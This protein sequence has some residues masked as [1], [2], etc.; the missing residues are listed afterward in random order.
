M[1]SLNFFTLLIAGSMLTACGETLENEQLPPDAEHG[2]ETLDGKGDSFSVRPG[3]PEAEAVLRYVNQPITSAAEGAQFRDAIDTKLHATAAKNIAKFRAG[4]DAAFG[5]ADDRT[6]ADLAA[7]DRVPYV[8]RTALMQLFELAEAAG[9]F[10]RASVDCAD[11]VEH[12]RYNN[13]VIDSYAD[14]LEYENSRCTTV[15]GNL[16]FKIQGTDLLPPAARFVRNLRHLQTV[17]GNVS[18]ETTNHITGIEFQGLQA[19]NGKLSVRTSAGRVH[20]VAFPALKTADDIYLANI[21]AN[22]F[23]SL[24][25][26]KKVELVNADYTGFSTLKNV[27][28]LTFKQ[29]EG[30]FPISFPA[31]TAAGSIATSAL[32][33]SS[34]QAPNIQFTGSFE[35][36]AKAGAI[37]FTHGNYAQL[38]FPKL[39][40]VGQMYTANTTEPYAGMSALTHVATLG[41]ELDIFNSGFHAGPVALE[42]V[43]S[44][45][46]NTRQPIRGY[47]KLQTAE[48]NL[49]L[50]TDAGLE[51]FN[52]LTSLGGTLNATL[53]RVRA[54]TNLSGFNKLTYIANLTVSSNQAP[55]SVGDFFKSLENVGGS[56]ALV[57]NN[58]FDKNPEFKALNSIG[59]NLRVDSLKSGADLMPLL[60]IVDGSVTVNQTPAELT[61][62]ARL[63]RI[64]GGLTLRAAVHKMTGMALLTAIGENLS[65][66]RT[67]SNTELDNFLNRLTE[68][69]GTINYN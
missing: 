68:F 9:F 16:S 20:T 2:L 64:E 58:G 48:G 65:I 55:V 12:D 38:A 17:N 5:T 69:S 32:S 11:Y 25:S 30:T 46:I 41:S 52:N 29:Q 44:M 34:W 49:S 54:Q 21:K 18:I 14:L 24:E 26:S 50:S 8:G 66:P 51:G 37:T 56:L 28:S 7:L 59:G 35:K 6:F 57:E 13:Y 4:S 27:E 53:G 36:L 62:F 47:D 61:G 23:A 15:N 60:E 45:T 42:N 67:L 43:D 19:V 1:K 63:E 31:L 22:P 40:E 3:T 39:I 10:T 33:A